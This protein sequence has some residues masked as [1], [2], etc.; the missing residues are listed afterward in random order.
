M[1]PDSKRAT[2]RGPGRPSKGN[3]PKLTREKVL[4]AALQR[5]DRDGID[6]LGIRALAADLGVAPNSLYWYV[7]D[8]DDLVHGVIERVFGNLEAPDP[9]ASEWRERIKQVCCWYRRRLLAHPN[10]VAAPGFRQ[11][12]P[13]SFLPLCVTLGSILDDAGFR[14]QDLVETMHGLFYQTIGFVTLEVARSE[15]GVPTRTDEFVLDQAGPAL[16]QGQ[17]EEATEMMSF[18]RDLDLD[19]VFERSL[20]STLA[21]LTVDPTG[22]DD[23]D[24]DSRG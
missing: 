18:V 16:E 22:R 21:G 14:G 8:K 12:F 9:T 13:F 24:D 17:V 23:G 4:E 3:T 11:T 19:A 5:V 6:S 1:S 15:R 7:R 20:D 2:K 10:V